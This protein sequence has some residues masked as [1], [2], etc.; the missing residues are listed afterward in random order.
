LPTV[1]GTSKRVTIGPEGGIVCVP[2]NPQQALPGRL[3]NG[4]EEY[5]YTRHQIYFP[6]DALSTT[7]TFLMRAPP[8]IGNFPI[9]AHTRAWHVERRGN[10]SIVEILTTETVTVNPLI[11]ARMTVQFID[12][13]PTV[14]WP[15]ELVPYAV[16]DVTTG[17]RISDMRI[18]EWTGTKWRPLN[19]PPTL[20]LGT[21]TLPV[22]SLG[23]G[24][25][26]AAPYVESSTRAD[27]WFLYR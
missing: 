6:P 27:R 5:I 12:D 7:Y 17:E 25:F 14:Q 26:A 24:I 23:T 22:K 19:T 3:Q 21:V 4:E 11:P 1:S 13:G 8:D 10:A 16:D 15:P 2:A 20:G 18:Y 9:Q